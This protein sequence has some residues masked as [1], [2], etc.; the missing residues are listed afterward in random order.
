M[1]KKPLSSTTDICTIECRVLP[2]TGHHY[3][4]IPFTE[5][6]LKTMG[7][8]TSSNPLVKMCNS[9]TEKW[10]NC[11]NQ[12]G[13]ECGWI[14]YRCGKRNNDNG[15]WIVIETN[16]GTAFRGDVISLH[17][18]VPDIP[19]DGAMRSPYAY[20]D[21]ADLVA[22]FPDKDDSITIPIHINTSPTAVLHVADVEIIW[23]QQQAA[24]I[25]VDLVID[26]GNT[27]SV[28]LALENNWAIASQANGRLGA[29]CKNIYFLPRGCDYP[30]ASSSPETE[31]RELITDSWFLL[32]EPMFANWDEETHCSM[33]LTDIYSNDEIEVKSTSNGFFGFVRRQI[34]KTVSAYTRTRI[35]PQMFVEISP[36]YMGSQAKEY[37]SNIDMSLGMNISMSSPKRYLWDRERYGISRGGEQC[38]NM[39]YNSWTGSVGRN[40]LPRLRGQICRYMYDDG[41]N[42]DISIPPSE[43]PDISK[44]PHMNP[45]HPCYPRSMA[46]V[47]SA[48]YILENAYRQ[49]NSEAWGEGNNP[50]IVRRINSVNVTFPSGW[51][52]AEREYYAEAWQQ[53][54]NI[55]TLAHLER[56]IILHEGESSYDIS[57]TDA[58]RMNMELDEAVAS[59]L[60]F[61]YSEVRRLHHANMW[62]KLYGRP[63]REGGGDYRTNRIRVLTVD[64]GGGTTDASI[65]EYGNT[66]P[67]AQVAL[68]Y[69]VLFRDC[70]SFA[71]DSVVCSLI[72]S[73]L[74]PSIMESRGLDPKDMESPE[75]IAFLNAVRT[76]I[77][78]QGEKSMW[79]RITQLLFL[80]IIRQWLTDLATC[81]E[82][83]YTGPDNV[84][85]RT[86]DECCGDA[87]RAI[88]DFNRCLKE[89]GID[90]DSF[91][92]ADTRLKYDH[93][94]VNRCI[95]N[96]LE[97]GLRPLG[98]FIAAYD[99]DLVTLSGKISEV[100]VVHN[101]LCDCLPIQPQRIIKM[102]NYLAGDWYPMSRNNLISDAKTVTAVGSALYIAAK[103]HLLGPRWSIAKDEQYQEQPMR[104]YWGIITN[105]VFDTDGIFMTPEEDDNA[106][107]TCGYYNNHHGHELMINTYI[108]RQKFISKNAHP[109]QQYQLCWEGAPEDAPIGTLA[110][111]F[112]RRL[113]ENAEDDDI[114]ISSV[115]PTSPDDADK[116]MSLVT[117]KLKTL[118]EAGFWMDE[119]RYEVTPEYAEE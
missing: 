96:V 64:I 85:Y 84:P 28:V 24:P 78:G 68:R 60:P 17:E 113:D 71:G 5:S 88:E 87:T 26:F 40:T 22:C 44:R 23:L 43:N 76:P 46:M 21:D 35:L 37:L 79:Q 54:V 73:I 10:R 16:M 45:E 81:K 90:S 83:Y 94:A 116:D 52:A 97:K 98:D 9:D 14:R 108:G 55:F 59:Q 36:A 20:A 111:I 67:G 63:N 38:W 119:C 8:M 80:P 57:Q 30:K 118:P 53:A 92:S 102:K 117:L 77:A 50:F 1:P 107:R 109:E 74:L 33:N 101:L 48:L 18:D 61:V 47:W 11:K 115:T 12:Q 100:P 51:I 103:Q 66:A 2:N 58:P 3:Y 72:Q 69:K 86:I 29:L 112:Q 13:E 106:G 114:E 49:I 95:C 39:N 15:V 56:N 41:R 75:T 70:N 31:P 42:W 99:I 19:E 82:G 25:D 6:L 27:R 7:G 65:V 32:Q 93:E 62:I 104:N 91:V 110:V 89:S 4:F 105:G 34:S